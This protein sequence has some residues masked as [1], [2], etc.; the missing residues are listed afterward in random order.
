MN[1]LEN[2]PKILI[3]AYGNAGRGDDALG[4][5]FLEMCRP[6]LSSEFAEHVTAS[7]DFQLN[8]EHAYTMS[9]YD[10]VLFVDAT[11]ND[12]HAFSFCQVHPLPPAS[13]TTHMLTPANV[14]H[15]CTDLYGRTP[16][17]FLL[18]IRGYDWRMMEGLSE[19][20]EKN[21]W[22]AFHFFQAKMEEWVRHTV[23]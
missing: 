3:H 13:F 9:E 22:S 17:T 8:V 21:L 20:A 15:L 16:E 10:I 7:H 4:F 14:L 12:V 1:T 19:K 11:K 5:A 18:Q 2:H 6:W 23:A